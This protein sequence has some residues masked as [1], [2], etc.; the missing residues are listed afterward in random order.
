MVDILGREGCLQK[1]LL[2]ESEMQ[3]LLPAPCALFCRL[4]LRAQPFSV[5]NMPESCM[6]RRSHECLVYG[7]ISG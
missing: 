4:F 5:I 1:V 7:M 6:Q 2:S 3:W